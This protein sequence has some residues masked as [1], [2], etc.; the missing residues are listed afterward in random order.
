MIASSA[1]RV[2][3]VVILW[4]VV[5][6]SVSARQEAGPAPP[7]PPPGQVLA[8]PLEGPATDLEPIPPDNP[9]RSRAV[10]PGARAD[11]GVSHDALKSDIAGNKAAKIYAPQQPPAPIA[12]RP[13]RGRPSARAVW[14]PGYW[15]WDTDRGEF[16][17]MGGVWQVP[18]PGMIWVGGRWARDQRGWYRVA[19]FWSPRRGARP[20]A[21]PA[22]PTTAPAW[23]ITGPPADHPPD[24]SAPAPGPD[25]FFV[26]GHFE[27][28]AGELSWK[29][30]FW[31]RS[32]PGW[33]WVPA[34]WVKRSTGWDFRSGDW[35]RE[36]QPTDLRVTV[37]GRRTADPDADADVDPLHPEVTLD[38][39]GVTIQGERPN[40]STQGPRGVVIL[41]EFGM[42]YYVI[43]PPGAFPY[44]PAGVVIPGAVPRF[45][46][47][48][49]DDVLP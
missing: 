31:A 23:R 49:L 44:G 3:C 14:V 6:Q 15:D 28:D 11:D 18:P 41:P 48:I 20:D 35:A 36:P 1:L 13:A 7:P 37:N 47:R 5:P 42:P 17:W 39:P 40:R 10:E 22:S 38:D 34:R 25:Y 46:R 4:A 30:G 21:A 24:T 27:P 43:R 45:V 32:Q 16:A 12:E 26:A 8:P 33:D 19:G 9:A 29:P 2:A